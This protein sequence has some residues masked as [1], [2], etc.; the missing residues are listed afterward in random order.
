[1]DDL[2]AGLSALELQLFIAVLHEHG[3][4]QQ[5]GGGGGAAA[6]GG[7]LNVSSRPLVMLVSR[8]L[9]LCDMLVEVFKQKVAIDFPPCIVSARVPYKQLLF[10]SYVQSVPVCRVIQALAGLAQK[11]LIFMVNAV[12][13]K[14]SMP[15]STL[16]LGT[17]GTELSG[18]AGSICSSTFV[19]LN[20]SYEQAIDAFRVKKAGSAGASDPRLVGR[21]KPVLQINERLR[22]A[23]LE[24]LVPVVYQSGGGVG[25]GLSLSAQ[26]TLTDGLKRKS[27]T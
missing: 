13:G 6:S 20:V 27:I 9:L 21:P 23:V 14:M 25:S 3:R 17:H 12:P 24:P 5:G 18:S 19:M 7:A 8:V 26:Q 1:V 2:L 22:R 4:N 16:S 15:V 11:G 10:F